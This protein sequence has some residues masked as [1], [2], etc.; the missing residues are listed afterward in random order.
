MQSIALNE[1]DAVIEAN[2]KNNV[3]IKDNEI[4]VIQGFYRSPGVQQSRSARFGPGVRSKE[5]ALGIVLA[6][7]EFQHRRLQD[8]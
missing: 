8:E 6:W 1:E 4:F 2:G 5:A 3:K 7:M